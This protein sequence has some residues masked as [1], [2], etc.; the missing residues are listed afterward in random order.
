MPYKLIFKGWRGYKYQ[1]QNIVGVGELTASRPLIGQLSPFL[2]SHWL[3]INPNTVF[4][5]PF[6]LPLPFSL[7]LQH[8]F[9]SEIQTELATTLQN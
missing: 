6:H 7:C 2:S 9:D 5:K 8:G 4:K 3:Q 1:I